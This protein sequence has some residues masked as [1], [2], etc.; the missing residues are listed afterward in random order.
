MKIEECTV[1]MDVRAK[2]TGVWVGQ[3]SA[4]HKDYVTVKLFS[5]DG[6]FVNIPPGELKEV[7]AS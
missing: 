2:R 6:F 4:V 5:P 3:L 7:V 1:G